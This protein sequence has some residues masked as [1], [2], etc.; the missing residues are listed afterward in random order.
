SETGLTLDIDK[1]PKT[2]VVGD[3][4]KF[5]ITVHNQG[6][7]AANRVAVLVQLPQALQLVK[8]SP[9]AADKGNGLVSFEPL[10]KLEAGA[11]KAVTFEVECK[12][13]KAGDARVQVRLTAPQLEGKGPVDAEESLSIGE[14]TDR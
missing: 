10:E 14:A 2:A 11:A 7:G 9:A 1:E 8:A 13:V 5:K 3:T 4:V 6:D 12:A